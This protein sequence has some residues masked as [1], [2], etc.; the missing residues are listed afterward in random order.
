MFKK[1]NDLKIR[2]KLLIGFG[3]IF[4]IIIIIGSYTIFA[5][6]RIQRDS[7][8]IE[9]RNFSGVKLS[10]EMK[11]AVL[12]IENLFSLFIVEQDLKFIESI[13]IQ[14][15][16]FHVLVS[17]FK[18][19]VLDETTKLKIEE[20]DRSFD[21]YCDIGMKMMQTYTNQGLKAGEK[22]RLTEF[23]ILEDE[24]YMKIHE[25]Q[26]DDIANLSLSLGKIDD[27]ARNTQLFSILLTLLSLILVLIITFILTKLI[28]SPLKKLIA[29]TK[30]ISRKDFDFPV[31]V[32]SRDEVG[33]LAFSFNQM[34]N[35]LKI[36]YEKLKQL[37]DSLAQQVKERTIDL[38]N[39]VTELETISMD[40]SLGLS[41][42]FQVLISV[43]KGDLDAKVNEE[44]G[45][46]LLSKLGEVINKTISNLKNMMN[47]II[48]G[49]EEADT[50]IK[51]VSVLIDRVEKEKS[52]NVRYENNYLV[53]CREVKKCDNTKCLAYNS[54]NL[55]CWQ[56]VGT[57][58]GDK[59]TEICAQNIQS[60]DEC[61][62][63]Q[64]ATPTLITKIGESF[65]S[66]MFI[67]DK[68]E[69]ELRGMQAK[70]LQSH[71]I[72]AIGQLAGGLAHEINNPMGAILGFSQSIVSE[73]KEDNDL[74]IPIKTIEREAI[75]CKKILGDL[76]TF[77]R[78]SK[79]VAEMIDINTVIAETLSLI[80]MQTKVVN[81][82]IIKDFE[83]DLPQIMANKG[84]I[85]QVIM[86]ICNNA[87]YEMPQGG[88]LTISTKLEAVD[89]KTKQIRI[90]IA[91]TGKGIPDEI[92]GKIFEPFFTTKEVGKDTGLG[93]SLC[94]EIVQKHNGT[95]EVQSEV[96]K[97]TTFL[98]GLPV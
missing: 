89:E 92:I 50:T 64:K 61:E 91:D 38:E 35:E 17:E 27:F 2:N 73:I 25:L 67:L 3:L 54:D 52:V 36:S 18:E 47:K 5:A 33:Q 7:R 86:N 88:N 85:Q 55:R 44:L 28:V 78:A 48:E 10:T 12:K 87:I 37:T 41:E 77:S 72:A 63:F 90:S 84:Q 57:H 46:E 71:K 39:A 13:D 34:A 20:I 80:E 59:L 81:V 1:F 9:L 22:I 68:K 75:R 53:R 66:M 16:K 74:Y 97:G 40:L 49:K 15:E 6:K 56:M 76:F 58:S 51:T 98:I 24:I 29:G 4:C 69:K 19:L 94:Y 21:N 23:N 65:N 31:E 45:N 62:V 11:I 43:S 32:K 42:I 60:C 14:K 8:Q 83:K 93:L 82:R 26:D 95:I 79:T 70:L 30:R 96:G